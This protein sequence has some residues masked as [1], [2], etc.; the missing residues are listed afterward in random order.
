M[1]RSALL[2]WGVLSTLCFSSVAT[3]SGEYS[4]TI[5]GQIKTPC[6]YGVCYPMRDLVVEIMESDFGRD[7][8][9]GWART[10]EYGW[11]TWTGTVTDQDGLTDP[12]IYL[13]AKFSGTRVT[14]S[15]S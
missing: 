7:D 15:H 5:R 9:E 4:L 6:A 13:R 1:R 2:L 8:V 12:E 14:L 3:A 10:D 11:F